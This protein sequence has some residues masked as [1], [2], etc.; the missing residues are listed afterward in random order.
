MAFEFAAA[1]KLF[2]LSPKLPFEENCSMRPFR[3]SGGLRG[4][5]NGMPKRS[6]HMVS[7]LKVQNAPQ[8]H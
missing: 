5:V 6:E 1:S 8:F 4:F 2:V 7:K 3:T